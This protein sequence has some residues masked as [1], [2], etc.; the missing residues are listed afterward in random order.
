MGR[1]GT[2][3]EPGP[4]GE[5]GDRGLPGPPGNRGIQGPQVCNKRILDS[6]YNETKKWHKWTECIRHFLYIQ[7]FYINIPINNNN[8][9]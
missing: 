6:N 4:A 7:N 2:Q 9:L 8:I 1:P 5:K 3:G